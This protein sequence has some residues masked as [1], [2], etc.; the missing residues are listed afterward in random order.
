MLSKEALNRIKEK[1]FD[2][3][4]QARL[5]MMWAR[6]HEDKYGWVWDVLRNHG[7]PSTEKVEPAYW[8]EPYN[9]SPETPSYTYI[10][11]ASLN[12]KLVKFAQMLDDSGFE[13]QADKLDEIVLL[14]KRTPRDVANSFWSVR[15]NEIKKNDSDSILRAFSLLEGFKDY[16]ELN[17]ADQEEAKRVVGDKILG[18]DDE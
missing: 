11:R 17:P 13:D 15:G 5:L 18:R 7:L 16:K 4:A 8:A 14:N 3:K 1:G 10:G 12:L 6:D 2:S 9:I